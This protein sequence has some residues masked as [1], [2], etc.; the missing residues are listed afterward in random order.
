MN[1]LTGLVGLLLALVCF[2]P[3]A[4][5]RTKG[6]IAAEDAPQFIGTR[7]TVCGKVMTTKYAQN[8]EGEPTFL[9][10]GAPF[11]KHPFQ[12]KIK[13]EDRANF[14]FAPE[15]TLDGKLICATGRIAGRGVRAE[16]TIESPSELAL[17]VDAS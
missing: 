2:D 6:Q 16:M 3:A 14:S 13:G 10:L 5:P 12:V 1:R 7:G 15:V 8:A 4:Q 11:P 9:H 17:G